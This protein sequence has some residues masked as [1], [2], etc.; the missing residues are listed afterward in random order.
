MPLELEGVGSEYSVLVLTG[1]S[2]AVLL[3]EM[4]EWRG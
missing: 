1:G 2:G 3:M 4:V